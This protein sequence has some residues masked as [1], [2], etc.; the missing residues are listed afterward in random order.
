MGFCGTTV[1]ASEAPD[2][3]TARGLFTGLVRAMAGSASGAGII[4]VV[5]AAS[6]QPI[7]FKTHPGHAPDRELLY[8][9]RGAVAGGAELG[10]LCSGKMAGIDDPKITEIPSLDGGNMSSARSVATFATNAG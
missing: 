4:C 5:A 1:V 6:L 8:V 3:V 2:V 10:E 7:A 9:P